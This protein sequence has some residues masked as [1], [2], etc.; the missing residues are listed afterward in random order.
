MNR[1]KGAIFLIMHSGHRDKYR[2]MA[3]LSL[4][5]I[6][7]L[8]TST[9]YR[10]LRSHRSVDSGNFLFSLYFKSYLLY[11]ILILS[12]FSVDRIRILFLEVQQCRY[13]ADG[14]RTDRTEPRS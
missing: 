3:R 13:V 12:I 9:A 14:S 8:F 6:V 11:K 4:F 1:A 5:Q 7:I 10:S 2:M